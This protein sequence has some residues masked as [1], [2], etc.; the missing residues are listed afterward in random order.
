MRR[1][2]PTELRWSGGAE[3][4]APA[5]AARVQR[6]RRLCGKLKPRTPAATV[7]RRVRELVL[8]L[9]A[10]RTRGA[11]T[12]AQR[13]LASAGRAAAEGVEEAVCTVARGT[14]AAPAAAGQRGT[15]KEGAVVSGWRQTETRGGAAEGAREHEGGR[16]VQQG[17]A[18]IIGEETAARS[19][20]GLASAS[21]IG[22]G[23]SARS[24]EGGASASTL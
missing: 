15:G 18:S 16:R 3:L 10:A 9:A 2:R 7:Q 8:L 12:M 20:E 17:N 4:L 21:T 13:G 1:P 6:E 22:E 14:R 19:A 24:A 11:P 5:L 23:A